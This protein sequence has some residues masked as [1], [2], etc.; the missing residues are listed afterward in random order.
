MRIALVLVSI[1]LAARATAAQAAADADWKKHL[2]PDSDHWKSVAQ[3]LVFNNDTEPETLDPGL[4]TGVP[5]SR[6]GLALFEGLIA[7]DPETL[8]ARPGMAS[9]WEISTDGLDYTFHL[10]PEAAWSDGK[11]LVAGDFV[12]SW[13][14]ALLPKTAAQYAY[15]LYP[16]AGAEEF[17]RG[18]TTDFATVGAKAPDDATLLVH[19]KQPC[20]WFLDLCAFQTLMPVRVEVIARWGDAWVRPEHLICNGPFMLKSWQP[21]GALVMVPNEHY[22]DRAQVRLRT[23]TALPYDDAETAYKKYQEGGL[24]WLFTVPVAKIDEVKRLPDYYAVPYL[25][26]YFYRFNCSRPPFDDARVRR[27]F[28]LALDRSV[29]TDHVLKGGQ[30]PATWFCPNVAGY[31]HV[32]GLAYDPAAAKKLLAE[33]GYGDQKPFPRVELLFNTSEAHK[34]VAESIVQQWHANLGV[35]VALRNS[36]WKVYLADTEKMDYQVARASWIG[37]YGDPNTFF[38]LWIT[39]GGNNRTGWSDKEYD[40]LLAQSQAERD[41]AKRIAILKQMETILVERELPV[42]PVYMYVNQGLLKDSVRG[43]HE[44]VRDIHPYQYLWLE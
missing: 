40:S 3:D 43:W 42:M 21:R 38:D 5:E 4:M 18:T 15:Q 23:L 39:N 24:H 29:I 30:K 44:N 17:N 32:A 27:A 19:L 33:A 34:Q 8:A 7:Y 22:W 25:G 9:A 36:E 6:L 13:R 2:Q 11:R 1:L 28:S 35:E 10:R 16:I 14:R 20:P 37:D 26:T 41:P 31:Q 12:A